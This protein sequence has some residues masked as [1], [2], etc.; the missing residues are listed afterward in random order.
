MSVARSVLALLLLATGP[1]CSSRAL[2][3]ESPGRGAGPREAL[4]RALDGAAL[5]GTIAVDVRVRLDGETVLALRLRGTVADGGTSYDV[6]IDGDPGFAGAAAGES[7]HLRLVG[8]RLFQRGPAVD[9]SVPGADGRWVETTASEL[10]DL[11]DV[12]LVGPGGVRLFELLDDPISVE[13]SEDGFVGT[14]GEVRLGDER[15]TG[16]AEADFAVTVR[17]GRA[18]AVQVALR[19]GAGVEMIVDARLDGPAAAVVPLPSGDEVMA[20]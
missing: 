6:T 7:H 17:D 12:G 15:I 9:R 5:D 18:V 19:D 2:A 10:A 3:P 11:P 14:L 13:V 8:G 4:R 20:G 1:A 16:A